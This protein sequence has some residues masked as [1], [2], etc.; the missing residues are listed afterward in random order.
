M[1]IGVLNVLEGSDGE[2]DLMHALTKPESLLSDEGTSPA[3]NTGDSPKGTARESVPLAHATHPTQPLEDE[4][5]S[6][7]EPVIVSYSRLRGIVDASNLPQ[8]VDPLN[9][10]QSLSDEEF[11]AVFAM[12]KEAFHRLPAWKRTSLKKQYGLF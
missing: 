12:E 6:R 5:G 9:R 2:I 7:S 8:G 3:S 4:T 10:E 1:Y 11:V